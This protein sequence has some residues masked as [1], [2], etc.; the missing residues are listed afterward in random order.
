MVR[1]LGF[2]AEHV[3]DPVL[4]AE[5]TAWDGLLAGAN[6][7]TGR[8]FA[9]FLAEDLD[10]V[11]APLA[12][13]ARRRQTRVDLFV[14]W[15]ARKTPNG[16]SRWLKNRR[17]AA[18]LSRMGVDL[19]LD[20]GPVEFIRSIAASEVVVSNSYHALMFALKFGKE[21]RIVLPT[22]PVRRKMNARL[23][24]FEGLVTG[25]PLVLPDLAAALSS[26]ESGERLSV[27][28]DELSARITAS[29]DWL[30]RVLNDIIQ[31]NGRISG[32]D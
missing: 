16:V 2:V 8:V 21:V 22:H 15:F 31:G 27:R 29:R 32:Q 13:F 23:R 10:A 3:V 19:H 26:L 4:L 6:P 20:A 1:A 7:E 30:S 28:T 5:R 24:E 14:D 25:A 11:A 9:Y 12:R 18:R 17:H